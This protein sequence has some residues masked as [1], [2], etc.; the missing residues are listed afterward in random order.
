MITVV[1]ITLYDVILQVYGFVSK[2]EPRTM[3]Y[4]GSSP[5][6]DVE[7]VFANGGDNIL[8]LLDDHIEEIKR[9]AIEKYFNN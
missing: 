4:I 3:D 5:E 9:L 7:C 1:E 8:A 6:F 2:G